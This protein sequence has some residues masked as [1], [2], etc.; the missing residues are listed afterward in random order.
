MLLRTLTELPGLSCN[1]RSLLR[2][3]EN[4]SIR[5]VTAC[6]RSVDLSVPVSHDLHIA[7]TGRYFIEKMVVTLYAVVFFLMIYN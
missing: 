4:H 2:K 3:T 5:K 6:Q 1:L 7:I